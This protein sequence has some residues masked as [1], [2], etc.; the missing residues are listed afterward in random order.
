[1]DIS[2][3]TQALIEKEGLEAPRITL[4]AIEAEVAGETYFTAAEG[5][6]G[7]HKTHGGEYQGTAPHHERLGLVTICVLVLRNGTPLVGY[8]CP[9]SAENFKEGVGRQAARH[10]A[11]AKVGDLLAFRLLDAQAT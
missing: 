7:A 4:A 8:S 9:V 3:A 1:M 2:Q 10:K 11:L 6:I 5:V